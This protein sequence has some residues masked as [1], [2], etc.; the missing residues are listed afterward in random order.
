MASLQAEGM[1]VPRSIN[2]IQPFAEL[3]EGSTTTVYKGYQSSLERFVLLK[4]L[5]P[6][7]SQD[8]DIARRFKEEARLVAKIQHPN[9]VTVYDYGKADGQVYLAAEYVEGTDLN[10]LLK[11]GRLPIEIA[12]FI[13]LQAAWGIKA[14]H[15][16][17]I[18]HRD[19]K[20][21]NLMLSQEG[22]VKLT[23]FGMASLI[24]HEE[25]VEV[26]GT[27]AYMAPEQVAGEPPRE[28]ADLFGLGAIL[29]EMLA[30]QQAFR[31]RSTSQVL[32]AV[33][34]H[35]P[36]PQ[37]DLHAGVPDTLRRILKKLLAKDP[38]ARY[39]RSEDVIAALEAFCKQ[40][41]LS[42]T[43]EVLRT[44]LDDPHAYRQE[45]KKLTS[46]NLLVAQTVREDI[47]TTAEVGA[48]SRLG[49]N[50]SASRTTLLLALVGLLLSGWGAYYFLGGTPDDTAHQSVPGYRADPAS[51]VGF[52][53]HVDDS[54][55]QVRSAREGLRNPDGLQGSV[56]VSIDGLLGPLAHPA[57]ESTSTE[58]Q[59][60]M[61]RL[62]V[63]SDP[64]ADVY[65]DGELLGTTPLSAPVSEGVHTLVLR[66]EGF[67]SYQAKVRVRAQQET[68]TDISLWSQVSRLLVEAPSGTRLYID[69]QFQ[70]TAP[71]E[72]PLVLAPGR[73]DLTLE[74]PDLGTK[75]HSF[76]LSAGAYDTL[77]FNDPDR[78]GW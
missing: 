51:P 66:K 43:R 22:R 2:G 60:S 4:V 13:L 3:H 72:T 26:R 33:V 58:Q 74:Y 77:R 14:A 11:S 39:A 25:D 15:S 48:L 6:A 53:Q 24:N 27:P 57:R 67:P 75:K 73:H 18:L 35:D 32:E 44:Y 49:A 10:Q 19:L 12:V 31:G 62:Q 69:G 70:V 9:V 71:Q 61:G 56:P 50:W 42:I 8:E 59:V 34:N 46:S 16:Q 45:R 37:L 1:G 21:G 65:V 17:G 28:A 7:F 78:I 55:R 5:K 76:R 40:H 52:G 29:Y 36:M 64:V 23:D 30:G 41:D 47:E 38:S 54:L 20:P 68:Q 63:S